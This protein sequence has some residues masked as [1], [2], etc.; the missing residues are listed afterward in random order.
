MRRTRLRSAVL[1]AAVTLTAA[2]CGTGAGGAPAVPEIDGARDLRGLD[3]CGLVADEQTQRLELPPEGVAGSA[4]EGPRC[5]WS[6]QATELTVVLYVHG[7]GIATL[8]EN[9]EPTTAR[10][11]VAG[12]PAL[13]TFTEDGAYCQY[14]VGVAADQVLLAG[15][16]GGEPDSCTA[17]Q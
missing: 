17:L 11:R 5:T 2:G 3:P 15:L 14:D 13:E 12:F 8:A 10:V 6:D 1:C 7:G 9:S 16:A 4:P